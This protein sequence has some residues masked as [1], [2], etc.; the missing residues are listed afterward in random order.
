MLWHV[1]SFSLVMV[2]DF[3]FVSSCAYVPVMIVL[4]FF[5]LSTGAIEAIAIA[6]TRMVC[7]APATIFFSNR[8]LLYQRRSLIGCKNVRYTL[9][10][11]L[12][13]FV[14]P[15]AFL[16]LPNFSDAWFAFVQS[17]VGAQW[18]HDILYHDFLPLLLRNVWPLL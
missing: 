11:S 3:T 18:H 2:A 1:I 16:S 8:L 15:F 5:G 4:E 7:V 10:L 17:A 12:V 14:V 13:A 9:L 6:I